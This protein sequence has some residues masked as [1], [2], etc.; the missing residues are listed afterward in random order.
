MLEIKD[1][2][3]TV[4]MQQT[5]VQAVSHVSLSIKP[6]RVLGLVGESGCGKTLT[7]QAIL[8]LG[9]HQ[10]ITKISGDIQLYGES[11]FTMS[12]K[13]LRKAGAVPNDLVLDRLGWRK[14]VRAII[15]GH[16]HLDHIG[17]IPYLAYRYPKA[18]ILGSG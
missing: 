16:A 4:P 2:S 7:A 11:I 17:A 14:K 10:G 12:E 6:G 1:L 5:A 15:V 9:E 13:Q 18:P 3:L 8:R